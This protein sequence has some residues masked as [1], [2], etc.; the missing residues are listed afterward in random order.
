MNV[1]NEEVNFR[2]I[3]K[4]WQEKWF[5]A[6]IFEPIENEKK[7]KFFFTVPYPYVSG[8][9]HVG[10][11][12]T[13]VSGDV[14]VR[15]KR[16][17]GFNVLWPVAFHITGTPV[18]SISQRLANGD[19]KV[20]QLYSEYVGIYEDDKSKISAIVE[21]F[22][23][24]WNIVNYF[25]KKMVIDFKSIGFSL[26]LSRQFTTGDKEYN[27][28]VSWQFYKLQEKKYLKQA[29]YPILYCPV[30]KNAVGEDDIIDA[31]TNKVEVQ[32]FCAIKFKLEDQDSYLASATM[33]ADTMF[34]ITNIFINP[35]D[36]Y[37]EV[38]LT[39]NEKVERVI[40][41]KDAVKKIKLQHE[42]VK[43][44]RE[45]PGSY[46][47][48]K[49]ALNPVN[50]KPIPIL[51]AGFV[52]SKTGTGVVHSV[53]AHAPFDYVA[54]EELK[55]D[56]K[57][58]EEY[59]DRNLKE[60]LQAITPLQVVKN[61]KYQAFPAAQLVNEKNIKTT[62]QNDVLKKI[63]TQ[64]YKDDFY[65]GKIINSG[66]FNG[67]NVEN[68]KEKMA[69]WAK[70]KKF[71][72]DF[73][74]T[75]R[76]ATTRSGGEVIVAVLQDQWFIDFN[77]PGWKEKANKC[78]ADS[79]TIFP[80]NYKK[81]FED[82][83]AWLNKRP[84]ARRRGLGTLL[85][86]NNE[87]IIES[88]SDSTLYPAFYTVIK[89]I[90]Q[91]EI[92]PEELTLEFFDFIFLG[93]GIAKSEKWNL[94][95][96]E[97]LYWY[98]NDQRHTAPAHI[99][100]HLSFYIFNHVA[101]FEE[102]HWPKS[103]TLNELLISE[104]TKMSKS[105][106]NVVTL[107]EIRRNY[108]ADLYRLYI[109]GTADFASVVDFRKKEIE[110]F[111]KKLSKFY[112]TLSEVI[113][114]SKQENKTTELT[115]ISNWIVSKFE[116]TIVNSQKAIE[117]LN[118]RRYIQESFF[119]ML[120]NWDYFT[121]RASAGEKITVAKHIAKRWVL[122]LTPVIPHACEELWEKLDEKEFASLQSWPAAQVDLI[123]KNSEKTQ[124]YLLALTEDLRKLI[125]LVTKKNNG[126]L[127]TKAK[128]IVAS[129][130]KW[131]DLLT[132]LLEENVETALLKTKNEHMKPYVEKW[133]HAFKEAQLREVNELA[134][135]QE[136]KNFLE[137]DTGLQITIENENASKSE[138][139]SKALPLKPSIELSN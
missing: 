3:E 55:K 115:A 42:N 84:C 13:Y 9:L 71:A 81:L 98:P 33:R 48:G 12:R 67:L 103:I 133:F 15:F 79:I 105:K 24:P 18:I 138:K 86:F 47:V 31:D 119:E 40:I 106:G 135:L 25:S 78:L 102:K 90:R 63:T 101:I 62:K 14:I 96:K 109:L 93:L 50:N 97:F 111:R 11:G 83:F 49:T 64:L 19:E 8:A 136:T 114:L 113:E 108:S 128:L 104:G 29:S 122:L 59:K 57:T 26:D 35:K 129:K 2:L 28:F 21:S 70:T 92:K 95:R 45:M 94:I 34:G 10:H 7:T 124:D 100:N 51:P 116:S 82:T 65:E 80:P 137:K 117:K 61:E 69:N 38:E 1:E 76:P 118:V 22:K 44:T 43:V 36:Y 77:A 53:P 110:T 121:K 20:K 88:L 16:M 17:Q 85:P 139:A 91:E 68:A 6:K 58:L 89:K 125:E 46:F 75:S 27:A 72:F 87:W 123:D 52:E 130:D 66:Q 37:E 134:A 30:D 73:Y 39:L 112:S 127:P 23:D 132:C 99:S 4:K 32:C 5:S 120:N 60:K 126:K 41:A 74:E 107:D 54:L 56:E 131:K